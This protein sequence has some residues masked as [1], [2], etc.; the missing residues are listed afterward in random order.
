MSLLP[1]RSNVVAHVYK[2]VVNDCQFIAVICASQVVLVLKMYIP[3]LRE[4]HIKGRGPRCVGEAG[5]PN[6]ER[7]GRQ[8][9]IF[10]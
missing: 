2:L 6:S 7:C 5:S 4:H 10:D 1:Q 8:G 9:V 3:P